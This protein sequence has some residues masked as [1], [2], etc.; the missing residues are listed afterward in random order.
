MSKLK[1]HKMIAQAMTMY[2]NTHNNF[3]PRSERI[4]IKKKKKTKKLVVKEST[5]KQR[6]IE[7][8]KPQIKYGR[9]TKRKMLCLGQVPYYWKDSPVA[10]LSQFPEIKELIPIKDLDNWSILINVYENAGEGIGEHIDSVKELEDCDVDSCNIFSKSVP[11]DDN[12][13]KK[14]PL[15][16][17]K[18]SETDSKK[19]Q[20]DLMA[21]GKIPD[22]A[23]GVCLQYPPLL[24]WYQPAAGLNEIDINKVIGKSMDLSSENMIGWRGQ[25]HQNCGL[26]HSAK[27]L[28]P[29][30]NITC[31]K[32]K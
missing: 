30:I 13:D 21:Q 5:W 3:T 6:V 25:T 10:R 18:W 11:I 20:L 17:M 27:T 1:S 9:P 19:M 8:A 2:N 28:V 7:L 31:R 29:R 12:I 26:K 4:T 32:L 24:N 16:R 22:N 15:V 23:N 14:T